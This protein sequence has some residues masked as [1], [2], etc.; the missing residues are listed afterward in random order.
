[1]ELSNS[2][3]NR[4][5][6]PTTMYSYLESTPMLPTNNSGLSQSYNTPESCSTDH[7]YNNHSSNTTGLHATNSSELPT[8]PRSGLSA[9]NSYLSHPHSPP[10]NS[11]ES[12]GNCSSRLYLP[13]SCR[14]QNIHSS[15]PTYNQSSMWP[16]MPSVAGSL[17]LP[18]FTSG[19]NSHGKD[20]GLPPVLDV[21]PNYN[22]DEVKFKL[23]QNSV[24]NYF[25]PH[26]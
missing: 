6:H 17:S 26:L 9:H 21:S 2:D 15:N 19:H 10:L 25:P 20:S 13:N 3:H 16:H 8:T 18:Q 11:P 14:S 4:W 5:F 7:Y 1:M 12:T 22:P 23:N 24:P